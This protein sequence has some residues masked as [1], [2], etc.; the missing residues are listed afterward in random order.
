[1][2]T[3]NSVFEGLYNKNVR[4]DFQSFQIAA[5]EASHPQNKD[6]TQPMALSKLRPFGLWYDSHFKGIDIS[7]VNFGGIFSVARNHIHQ[8]SKEYYANLLREFPDNSNPEVGHYFERAW[9]AVFHPIPKECLYYTEE[10]VSFSFYYILLLMLIFII[11]LIYHKPLFKFLYKRVT[12]S[13][14]F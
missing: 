10:V 8:H 2:Q 3:N 7:L 4:D 14:L 12:S 11:V 5:Y 1:L 9:V 13:S 6:N